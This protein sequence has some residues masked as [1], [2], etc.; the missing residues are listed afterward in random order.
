ME[1]ADV[2]RLT[3]E[4]LPKLY[5]FCLKKTSDRG[6]AEDLTQ[7][8]AL[9]VLTALR[10]G[11]QPEN[12]SAY[13]WKIARNRY[14]AWADGKRRRR[15]AADVPEQAD[16]GDTPPEALIRREELA[17]LRR[18]LAFVR[19]EYRELL[20]ARYLEG[21]SIREIAA[22]VSL[23]EDAV[24]QRLHRAQKTLKE[25][26]EMA[27]EFGAHSYRPE[28]VSF[29]VNGV[30]APQALL[31]S[32][33]CK[34]LLLAAYRA[35]ST[36]GE[37]AMEL[38]VALPYTEEA[39]QRLTDAALLRKNGRRYETG[40][41]IVSAAAQTAADA[42]LRSCASAIG[43][44]VCAAV[45]YEIEW[46][47][48]NRPGWRRGL[49]SEAEMRWALLMEAAD[50]VRQS[51]LAQFPP[52]AP[53]PVGPWGFTLRPDGGEWDVLGLEEADSLPYVSC[54]G[55]VLDPGEMELPYIDFRHYRFPAALTSADAP[56]HTPPPL[57]YADGRT[58]AAV[59]A[60]EDVRAED[61][62]CARLERLGYLKKTDG[63]YA[64]AFLVVDR[65]KR[66]SMPDGPR[67]RLQAL[68][69][70]ARDAAVG[71][72][73]FCRE[74]ILRE[75]PAFLR[76]DRVQLDHA[77]GNLF[78]LRYALAEDALRQGWL[79]RETDGD[80]RMRGAMLTL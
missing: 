29:I 7:D 44:A 63:G 59:A 12:F 62:A 11:R 52:P 22:A 40:F 38:G 32:L 31:D 79:A 55:C 51:V 80:P 71:Q 15:A 47:D 60:G 21:R 24:K 68:R 25:G 9:Q 46:L 20:A 34:N 72:Y 10:G 49:Q 48:E 69:D 36:A 53:Q 61:A 18:E 70:A 41:C 2:A 74:L 33:L 37:L 16:S 19:G 3:E 35:P 54:A 58:L 66:A 30:G 4:L 65:E 50:L 75:L 5:S 78:A 76:N 13:V 45:A 42:H 14:A 56:P 57:S 64:C 27:R 67:A 6:E 8:I 28:N 1:S 73:R 26:M 23:S 77:C 43:E 17:L 39:L